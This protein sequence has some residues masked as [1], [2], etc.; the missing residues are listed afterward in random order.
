MLPD[1]VTQ[2]YQQTAAPHAP[3]QAPMP[4]GVYEPRNGRGG[5]GG[6]SA[7]WAALAFIA[8]S[9]LTTILMLVILAPR[10]VTSE[11]TQAGSVAFTVTVTDTLLSTALGAN[12]QA[13]GITLTQLHAHIQA[14]GQIA[15]TAAVQGASTAAG[16]SVTVILQPYVSQR[17]LTV[18]ILRASLDNIALPPE[19]LNALRDQINQQLAQSSRVSFGSGQAL[20]VSGVSFASG[21]MT[22][23]YAPA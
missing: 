11:T 19:I 2:P 4:Q 16:N 14:N 8:G 6:R 17:T 10:P 23:A 1:D 9:L 22:I 13:G 3:W 7:L 5:H 20:E 18:K 21:A 12:Q 15:I